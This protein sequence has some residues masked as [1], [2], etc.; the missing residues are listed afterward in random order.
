M[1]TKQYTQSERTLAARARSKRRRETG[2]SVGSG[3]GSVTV[4]QNV[5][6]GSSVTQGDGH[7]HANKSSLDQLSVASGY[8]KVGT[9]KAKAGYAEY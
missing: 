8:V 4:V 5:T 7:T 1:A 6:A 2:G 9:A 3:G